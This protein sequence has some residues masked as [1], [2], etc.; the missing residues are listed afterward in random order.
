[1]GKNKMTYY[2]KR[3]SK[4]SD[5]IRLFKSELKEEPEN[6]YFYKIVWINGYKW[7]KK[8]EI[9]D[10]I[11]RDGF[12]DLPAWTYELISEEEWEWAMIN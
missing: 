5:H 12:H 6:K 3:T 8:K 7:S 10:S 4:D 2:F 11:I 1:M 9:V